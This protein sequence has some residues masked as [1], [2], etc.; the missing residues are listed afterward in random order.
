MS[1]GVIKHYS[2]PNQP[3]PV[4][5]RQPAWK[6]VSFDPFAPKLHRQRL[7]EINVHHMYSVLCKSKQNQIKFR[8]LLVV[9]PTKNTDIV[10]ILR[11]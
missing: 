7:T 2:E 10:H 6:S 3:L 4:I 8:G 5:D 9:T 11:F 1:T